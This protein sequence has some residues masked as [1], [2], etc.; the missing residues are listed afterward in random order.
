MLLPARDRQL[1]G[2]IEPLADP[3]EEVF[4]SHLGDPVKQS[5]IGDLPEHP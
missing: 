1:S 3:L 5:S 2:L 4:D